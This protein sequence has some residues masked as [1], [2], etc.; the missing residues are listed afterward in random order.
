MRWAA[1]RTLSLPETVTAGRWQY[2][3]M[4]IAALPELVTASGSIDRASSR[5]VSEEH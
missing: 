3:P 2:A 1:E 5:S 4:L